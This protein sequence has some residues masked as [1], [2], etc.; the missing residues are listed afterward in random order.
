MQVALVQWTLPVTT[1]T[2]FLRSCKSSR[3]RWSTSSRSARGSLLSGTAPPSQPALSLCPGV[4]QSLPQSKTRAL[5]QSKPAAL[6][7]SRTGQPAQQVQFVY[8]AFPFNSG[9]GSLLFIQGPPHP[10]PPCPPHPPNPAPAWHMDPVS[11]VRNAVVCCAIRA[12]GYHVEVA[13]RKPV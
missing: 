10:L 11:T 12:C 3:R 13:A 1:C 7:Q 9:G 6:H 2:C 8:T 4:A 5:P